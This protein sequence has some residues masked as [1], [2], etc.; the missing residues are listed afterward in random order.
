MTVDLDRMIVVETNER[1]VV[2]QTSEG[3]VRHENDRFE[4]PTTVNKSKS[5]T[6]QRGYKGGFNDKYRERLRDLFGHDDPPVL[7][8]H[9]ER[10][11]LN[12]LEIE[13]KLFHEN[14]DQ[15]PTKERDQNI[16]QIQIFSNVI[17]KESLQEKY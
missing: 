8:A 5:S 3:R 10:E 7:K 14:V 1:V 13:A 2:L 9:V 12:G 17:L 16:D 15:S 11:L 6:F 4:G